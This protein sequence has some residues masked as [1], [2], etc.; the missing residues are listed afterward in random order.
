MEF[1]YIAP[2]TFMMGSPAGELGEKSTENQHQVTLTQGYYMQATEV[3][4]GQ[5]EAVMG[6]NPNPSPLLP[7]G[8]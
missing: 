1:V 3:T 2:G 8:I 4:Q 7:T 6:S 5:W